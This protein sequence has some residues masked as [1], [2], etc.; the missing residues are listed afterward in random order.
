MAMAVNSQLNFLYY[1]KYIESINLSEV[2]PSTDVPS[3]EGSQI[4]KMNWLKTPPA[5]AESTTGS[6]PL[7]SERHFSFHSVT[8]EVSPPASIS[9]TNVLCVTALLRYN[10]EIILFYV[11]YLCDVTD[12]SNNADNYDEDNDDDDNADSNDSDDDDGN[13]MAFQF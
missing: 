11:I 13:T 5:P 10:T 7:N 2:V 1:K 3:T 4:D 8:D 9:H 12:Y 6:T